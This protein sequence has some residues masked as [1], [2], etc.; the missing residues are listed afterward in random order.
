[1]V[2]K[3]NDYVSSATLEKLLEDKK[4]PDEKKEEI[5]ALLPTVSFVSITISILQSK[6]LTKPVSMN[7]FQESAALQKMMII[8]INMIVLISATMI[9]QFHT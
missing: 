5:R 8:M 6:N 9:Q 2:Y 4:L 7:D 3:N 1:M